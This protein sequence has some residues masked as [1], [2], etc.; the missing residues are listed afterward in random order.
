MSASGK[1]FTHEELMTTSGKSFTHEE[2][3]WQLSYL[4]GAVSQARNRLRELEKDSDDIENLKWQYHLQ[5]R[6]LGE[7]D[8][9]RLRVE[10]RTKSAL[11]VRACYNRLRAKAA[12]KWDE[13]HKAKR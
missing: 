3:Q 10:S 2:L 6:A 5:R 8:R 4:E 11:I 12:A 1:S 13:V 7:S 9:S